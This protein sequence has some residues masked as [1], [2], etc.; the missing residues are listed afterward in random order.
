MSLH[1]RLK[2]AGKAALLHFCASLFVAGVA[3]I[4]VFLVWYPHPYSLLS[5]GLKL[6]AIVVVV[7]VVCG[8][9]LTLILFSPL[10]SK[11]EVSIDLA[12]VIAIQLGA[13]AYGVYTVHQVRPL[14]LVHEVDRFRVISMPDFGDIDISKELASLPPDLSPRLF[15]GPIVVGIRS[16]SSSAERKEV[17]LESVFGGRDYSQRPGFYVPYDE[18]YAPKALLRSRSLESFVKYYPQTE[19]EAVRILSEARVEMKSTRFLPV[20]HKQEWIAI[21]APTGKILGFLPGDG[22]VVP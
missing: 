14:Y 8:P 10:K 22:F 7:D 17:M 2:A 20:L 12:L 15:D 11:R 21:L 1:F 9:L 18:N 6:F 19:R 4:V 5:G 13:L 16:V 3:A